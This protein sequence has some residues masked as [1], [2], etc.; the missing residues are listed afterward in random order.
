[1]VS[2]NVSQILQATRDLS[3]AECDELCQLLAERAG[4]QTE[5]SLQS[6]FRQAMV[7]RGL[8]SPTPPEGQDPERMR[9]WKPVPL[10]GDKLVSDV[11]IEERR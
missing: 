4:R 8:L 7:K 10:L 11:I 2:P 5:Q 6:Q 1:M 3:D 9:Q